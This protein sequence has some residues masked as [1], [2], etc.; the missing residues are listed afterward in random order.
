MQLMTDQAK[1]NTNKIKWWL[2]I[3]KLKGVSKKKTKIDEMELGYSN[4]EE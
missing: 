4:C 3:S 2:S 1:E